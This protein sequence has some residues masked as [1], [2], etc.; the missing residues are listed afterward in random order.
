MRQKIRT[1]LVHPVYRTD[2]FGM[3]YLACPRK[4]NPMSESSKRNITIANYVAGILG[5][6]AFVLL[7]ILWVSFGPNI[8]TPLIAGIGLFFFSIIL[9]N[10]KGF[11]QLGR[12]ALCLIPPQLILAGALLAKLYDPGFTDI[13]YYDARFFII[14]LSIVPCLIF[15]T[16]EYVKLGSSLFVILMSLILFDPIHELLGVG[17][18][19]RGFESHSYYYINHAALITFAGITA[20]AIAMK[21]VIEK[22]E[23]KNLE[24]KLDLVEKNIQLSEL[25]KNVETQNEEIMSQSDELYASQEQLLAANRIIEKQ[26]M[27]LQLQVMQVNSDLEEANKELIKHN[28]ELRQ[29]S[30]TISHN[31][32]GPIARLLGLAYLASMDRDLSEQTEALTIINHIKSAAL[33]LDNVIRDLSDIVD[34]RNQIY[35]LKQRIDFAN[36]WQ[37]VKALLQITEEMEARHFQ[38]DFTQA[39]YIYSIKPMI[40]SI[41]FNLV[42]NAIK[43]QSPDRDLQIN[44]RTFE[45][46]DF[47]VLEVRDNGLGIDIH[48]F[49]NDLFK[50]YKRFHTHQ[51]GKGLGLYLIKSQAESL[52]GHVEIDSAPGQGTVFKVFIKNSSVEE[53]QQADV[54]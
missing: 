27:E 1:F 24:F 2:F 38:L 5:L 20:G 28:N 19:Q 31:L 35:Q 54:T 42:S 50:M 45:E 25:L 41:L 10:R 46:G 30:Y 15:S 3:K 14:L 51:E 12:M 13:L 33:D 11:D 29:F 7:L 43:Y 4:K 16:S 21:I 32:R 8:N 6:L 49:Q 48:L 26:K 44:I 39:A 22:T 52:N 53:T 9:L 37:E 23:Q 17:Y 18:F 36:E 47:T 34:I 40:S